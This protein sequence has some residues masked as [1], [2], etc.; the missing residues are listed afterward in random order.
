MNRLK[1]LFDQKKNNILS[2]Y[3]T[4]GYPEIGATLK[5]AEALEKAGADFLEIGFPYSDP[6]ADGPVIQ[7]SSQVAIEN[8]MTLKILFQ[9]LKDLRSRVSIPILLMGYANPMIQYGVANFCK[10]AAEVGVD[11]V[12]VPDLPLSEYEELYKD[13][14]IKNGLSN[15]FLVTPQTSEERIRKIDSLS[16][17][18]IYLLSSSATTGKDLN[19]S[20]AIGDY[21]QRVKDMNLNNP[22]I[23]GFGISD[24]QSFDRANKY[25]AGAIV[26]TAFVKT[27]SDS[28]NYLAHIPSF[29]KKIKG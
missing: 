27:L 8:G 12:I 7:N 14:F 6:L 24:K 23:I 28:T 21:Y 4:A 2:I 1:E 29:I 26:G 20:D 22:L 17:G 16:T 18:F 10:A 25:A 19:V 13:D 9:Q 11:G 15:I 3:F 5:I